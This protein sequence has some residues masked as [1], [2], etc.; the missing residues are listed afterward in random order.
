MA[1][2]ASI[3]VVAQLQP[4]HADPCRIK[5]VSMRPSE[6]RRLVFCATGFCHMLAQFMA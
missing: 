1:L 5:V 3:R 2:N 4:I 6:S